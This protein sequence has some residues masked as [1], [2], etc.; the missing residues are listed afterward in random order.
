MCMHRAECTNRYSGQY[1]AYYTISAL[2]K[3]RKKLVH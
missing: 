1:I 2:S 3:D